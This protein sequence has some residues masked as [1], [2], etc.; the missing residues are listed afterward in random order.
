MATFEAKT[1]QQQTD[2]ETG[3]ASYDEQA[4]QACREAYFLKQQ[5]QILQS[6]QQN[7]GTTTSAETLNGNSA[8][9]T[10]NATEATLTISPVLFMLILVAI[11][12]ATAIIVKGRKFNL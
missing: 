11:V 3:C 7:N 2:P 12:A 10:T 4:F 1:F 6:Q 8:N 9:G 5:N